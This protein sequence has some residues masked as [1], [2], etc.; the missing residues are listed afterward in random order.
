MSDKRALFN[1][2]A[3][4]TKAAAGALAASKPVNEG[5]NVCPERPKYKPRTRVRRYRAVRR[6]R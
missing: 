4:M 3:N 1:F 6:R 5:C 2:F